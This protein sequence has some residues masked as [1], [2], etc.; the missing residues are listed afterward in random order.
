[1][2]PVL[3]HDYLLTMRG[4]ERTFAAMADLWPEAP[5]ATLLHDP[6][7]LGV[8]FAGRE[9]RSSFLQRFGAS[10]HNFRALLPA[11]P[12]AAHQLDVAGGD[13]VLSSSSA[14]AHGV[15][16]PEGVP[17]VCYCHS[18]FR[19]AWH[20]RA[21][22]VAEAPPPLRPAMA[23][24][25]TAVRHWDRSAARRTTAYI[26]NSAVTQQRI[27][28]FWG[29]EAQVVHPP[30]AVERFSPGAAEDFFLVVAELVPHK[31]VGLALEAAQR[32]RQPVKVVGTGPQLEE[33]RTRFGASAEFLGRLEDP[34]LVDLYIRCRALIIPNIEEFGIVGVEAQ[35]AGRP[36]VA[37]GAGGALE[38]VVDG[39]T[40]IHVTP[41][42]VDHLTEA[43]RDGDFEHYDPRRAVANA[44]R[45]S[46]AS[47]S[48]RLR[49][50]VAAVLS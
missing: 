31:R 7:A 27:A 14:F 4:A 17:H 20:E 46:T 41:D 9:V 19:Y 12:L 13:L 33:L 38:T 25:L 24:V 22:G 32:A 28:R 16:P 48:E 34:E 30:V 8:G 37:A 29:R 40:G 45:F 39:V 50:A 47:F 2:N 35:A 1:M 6:R 44:A 26:A 5:I 11:F 15:R 21:R 36:V 42:D 23:T 18:P 10:Q 43:L 49:A 3:A